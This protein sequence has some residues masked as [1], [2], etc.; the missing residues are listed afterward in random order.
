VTFSFCSRIGI[1]ILYKNWNSYFV[2]NLDFHFIKH[3]SREKTL[4]FQFLLLSLGSCAAFSRDLTL[5]SLNPFFIYLKN[6]FK[7]HYTFCT[8]I[9]FSILYKIWIFYFIE[10]WIF[11]FIKH[12][13]RE[14]TFI[15]FLWVLMRLSLGSCAAYGTR[16]LTQDPLSP[17]FIYLKY[18]YL[19]K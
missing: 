13:S 4:S 7:E 16:D 12:F 8:R 2:Q 1:H 11:Y 17:F 6:L 18:L 5:A 10:I 15:H 19:K 9:G 3:F 14:K